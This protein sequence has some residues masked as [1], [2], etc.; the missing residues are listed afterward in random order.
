MK[1]P[2]FVVGCVRSGT[3]LLRN[4]LR[5]HP[6]LWCSEETQYYRW[7]DAFGM[8]G[9]MNQVGRSPLMKRHRQI[10]GVDEERFQELLA[11]ARSRKDLLERFA[12]EYLRVKG[13]PDGRWF[14]KSPQNVYGIPLLMHDFPGAKFVHIVRNPLN[15]VAS[16]I[17]GKVIAAPNVVA[18]ANYW[19]EAVAIVNT[20]KPMLG[21][22]LHEFRYEDL[23]ADPQGETARLVAFLGEDPSL[24]EF[25]HDVHGEKDQHRATLTDAD[26]E[27]LLE[28][29]GEWTEFYGYD[30][31]VEAVGDVVRL[32]SA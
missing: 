20:C 25:T 2:F 12:N 30:L 27:A 11:L 1:P 24:L 8:P 28:I 13:A 31:G 14:D 3:T 4:L 29:C 15:V 5:N 10:D 26:R 21:D 9:F 19:R 18:A 32:E 6:N 23:V 22:A 17:I 16:L 7:G